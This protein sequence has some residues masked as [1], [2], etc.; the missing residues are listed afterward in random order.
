MKHIKHL[1]QI[2]GELNPRAKT[3]SSVSHQSLHSKAKNISVFPAAMPMK[4]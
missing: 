1:D 4:K 2:V 3:N